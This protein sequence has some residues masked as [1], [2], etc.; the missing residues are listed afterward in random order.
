MGDD[1][2]GRFSL[3]QRGAE[4]HFAVGVALMAVLPALTLGYLVTMDLL[5]FEEPAQ[6]CLALALVVFVTGILG[7]A[8]LRKYPDSVAKLRAYTGRMAAG[9]L[10]EDVVLSG[11]ESDISAIESSMKRIV[12]R[13]KE[14][15]DTLE[16]ERS[17]LEQR[18]HLAQKMAGMGVMAGGIARD[19]GDLL[20][21]I[22]AQVESLQD[23]LEA[24]S[25]A[26]ACA[27][28]I[29]QNV[30]KGWALS[31]LLQLYGSGGSA[32]MSELD[33]VSVLREIIGLLEAYVLDKAELTVELPDGLP[34][35]RGDVTQVQQL[36]TNLVMN[37]VDA[38]GD[39]KGAVKVSLAVAD[40]TE[41]E[42]ADAQPAAQVRA[43]RFVCLEVADAGRGMGAE[44]KARIFDPF[45]STKPG[46]RGTGLAVVLGIIRAHDGMILVASEPGEG[47][48]VRALFPVADG[49]E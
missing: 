30:D 18:L 48:T 25:G 17:V 34:S 2:R 14:R 27:D 37:A 15:V 4:R 11:D 39:G 19:L 40:F 8:V 33:P 23:E 13:L 5:G 12:E 10:P 42:L 44:E 45:F 28:E 32:E 31:D 7:F 24:G 46:R 49:A 38:V 43:G 6:V 41:A 21:G 22:Q 36:A 16:V 35:I 1:R 9:E 3:A 47:T 20:N 26:W 29:A